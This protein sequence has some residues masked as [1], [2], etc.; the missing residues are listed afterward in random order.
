ML[1]LIGYL[2]LDSLF[3]MLSFRN[4]HGIF[5]H[6]NILLNKKDGGFKSKI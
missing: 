1:N 6:V 3:V 5:I 2:I 4:F